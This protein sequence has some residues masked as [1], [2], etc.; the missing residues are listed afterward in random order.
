MNSGPN[1][2]DALFSGEIARR[3]EMA[4]E[5]LSI[6]QRS[7]FL[8][9]HEEDYSLDEI[10]EILNIDTGT[11]KAHMARAIEK[12]RQELRDLYGKQTFE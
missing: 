12:L 4:L 3:L 7:V 9:R 5:K 11:V 10:G 1:Q 2:E 6:R 8:L